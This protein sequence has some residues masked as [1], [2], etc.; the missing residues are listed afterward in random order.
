MNKTFTKEQL[1]SWITDLQEAAKNDEQFLVDWFKRTKECPFS[2]IGGWMDGFNPNEAD[3]FCQSKSNPTYAM[4]IKICVN[5]GPYAYTDFEMLD[6]PM[7]EDGE[8]DDN[9]IA[10]EWGDDPAKV[11]EFF[12]IEWEQL[13]DTCVA[14][15]EEE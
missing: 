7:T 1:T 10:L 2:I 9:C 5:K 13:M 4:C 14:E 3:L 8:V 12:M 6:M 15:D 11:A